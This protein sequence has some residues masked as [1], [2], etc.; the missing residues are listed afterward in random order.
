[1]MGIGGLKAL[2]YFT[3]PPE[4]LPSAYSDNITVGFQVNNVSHEISN[5]EWLST[6]E[7]NAIILKQ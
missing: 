7:A 6:I 3:L 5:N 1:M 2:Q 4:I